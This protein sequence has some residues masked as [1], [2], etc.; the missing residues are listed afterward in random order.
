MKFVERSLADFPLKLEVS[1]RNIGKLYPIFWVGGKKLYQH[2]TLDDG[3]GQKYQ[4]S[5]HKLCH[6]YEYLQDITAI[7]HWQTVV[8]P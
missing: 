8:R 5:Y 3:V 4:L 7:I 1:D 2:R 6:E